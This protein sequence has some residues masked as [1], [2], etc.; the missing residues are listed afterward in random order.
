MIVPKTSFKTD[1]ARLIANVDFINDILRQFI[2]ILLS[3]LIANVGFINDILQ[4]YIVIG[5]FKTLI[6]STTFF[7][8]T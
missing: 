6:L 1:I 2:V 8:T 5:S 3:R 7:K 4:T